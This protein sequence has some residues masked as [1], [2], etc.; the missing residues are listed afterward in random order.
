MNAPAPATAFPERVHAGGQTGVDRAALDAALAAG[1]PCGG[2]CPAGRAAEDGP[3]AGRYP[4][5]ET[6]LARSTQRT[7]WNV[8][9]TDATLVLLWG[10]PAG[11]TALTLAATRRL[12]RPCLQVRLDAENAGAAAE[13]VRGWLAAHRVGTLNVAGPRESEAPGVY[14]AARALL[15][16]VLRRAATP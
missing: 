9:D 12:K 15:E 13:Q 4:L 3:I 10:P 2:W 8:R 14:A 11:G 1:V 6:P 7:V 16:R 5:H